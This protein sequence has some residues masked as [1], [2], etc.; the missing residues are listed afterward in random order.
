M[1][2]EN[3]SYAAR[4]LCMEIE[5]MNNA[6]IENGTSDR[7][8]FRKMASMMQAELEKSP[9]HRYGFLLALSEFI[10]AALE[11]SVIIPNKWKPLD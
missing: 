11:G 1:S 7:P 8:D 3:G 6:A 10:S 5:N 4:D 2:I 9:A